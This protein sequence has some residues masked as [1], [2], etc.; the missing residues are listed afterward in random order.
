V[1]API[2]Q[3][4]NRAPRAVL[5]GVPA[6]VG[7]LSAAALSVLAAV[8]HWWERRAA[9]AGLSDEALDVQNAVAAVP[10]LDPSVLAAVP[11]RHDLIDATPDELGAEYVC[12]L[13]SA[14]RNAGGRHYTPP[15]LADELWAQAMT[16]LG[17]PP[18]ELVVDPAC[19][20]GALLLPPLRALLEWRAEMQPELLL[21][22][23][24][25]LIAGRDVDGAATWLGSV[26]LASELLPLWARVPGERRRPLPALC[27]TGDGLA[28]PARPAQVVVMNPPYGRVRLSDEERARYADVLYGHANLYALF[29]AAALRQVIDGGVVAALVPAGWLGGAYFQRLRSVFGKEAPLAQLSFVGDRSG[30]FA[31][32]VLQETVIAS[33]A[34]GVKARTV[35]CRRVVLDVEGAVSTASIGTAHLPRARDCDLPWLLPRNASD[36]PLVEAARSMSAR[37]E[38]Y[39]W[40]ISTGPLVWN[41]LRPRLSKRRRKGSVRVLWAADMADGVVTQHPARDTLRYCELR[42]DQERSVFVLD[43]PAVLVQRTTAPEQ[44]RR[45]LAAALDAETLAAWGGEVVVENHVNVLTCNRQDSP[46]TTRVLVRLLDSPILDRLY[47][48]LTGSVAVSAYEISALP[49]PPA[50]VLRTWADLG[51]DALDAA[52][53]AAYGRDS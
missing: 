25:S 4:T 45:L 38:T 13:D 36:V 5:D 50:T 10:P 31:T 18:E 17:S 9:A 19:G 41:R 40:K 48:C 6:A 30:V 1:A 46:L 49:L 27:T 16:V 21:A 42:T 51:D 33:F 52:I 37:L 26:L 34:V 12:A 29:M 47:R 15:G 32:G 14:V 24:P 44:P 20:A 43:Q 3:R 53:A 7:D 22:A 2:A 8:P 35:E 23:L 39:G 11:P 28:A